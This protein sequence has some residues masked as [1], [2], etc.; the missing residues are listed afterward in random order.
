[1]ARTCSANSPGVT[2]PRRT[3]RKPSI[4][5]DSWRSSTAA[6][7]LDGLPVNIRLAGLARSVGECDL[8]R[9]EL[10]AIREELVQR[11][12]QQ[13]DV[14]RE[15]VHRVEQVREVLALQGQQRRQCLCAFLGGV[16]DD[17]PFD[18]RATIAE[19]HVLGSAQTDP[20]CAKGSRPNGVLGGV[21]VGADRQPA[22][23]VGMG[24][25]PI[26]GVDRAAVSSSVPSRAAPRAGLDV[27]LDGEGT[28]GTAPRKISPVD[29]SML[30]ASPSSITASPTR[31]VRAAASTSSASAPH[32]QVLPIPRAT[33]AACDVFPP[34][35]VRIPF[36]AIM[37]SRSSG[38]VSLRTNT[39]CSP[40]S[41]HALAV[42]ESNTARP[43]AAPGDAAIPRVSSS[44]CADRRL[45]EHQQRSCDPDTR[46]SASST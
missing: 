21:G 16:G 39:T 19:E 44:R 27:G 26:D 24:E 14:H 38:L 1:M 6:N 5:F 4:G 13:P 45:R 17:D 28:T 31:A 18:E 25:E 30:I 33:T 2:R 11:R 3:P 37:P 34:R 40:R 10:G 43:T 9:T 36:A 7:S 46:D 41:C 29:P 42:A 35:A 32:T 22:G 15:T 8:D 23:F 12:V 20:L